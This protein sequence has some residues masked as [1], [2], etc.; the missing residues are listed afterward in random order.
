[1]I[2]RL[3]FAV[4]LFAGSL[5]FGWLLGRRRVLTEA[6]AGGLLRFD[7]KVLS[8]LVLTLLFWR[9]DLTNW[10]AFSLPLLGCVALFSTW[11]P[12]WM[13]ARL[14]GLS[15]PETGSFVTCAMFSNVGYLG[16]LIAFA[17]YGEPGYALASL[18]LVYFS[19]CFYVVAFTIARRFGAL[20]GPMRDEAG[21][22]KLR[23]YP[24]M[25][26]CAGLLL[27]AAHIPRPV[28]LEWLSHVLIPLESACY[29][30]AIGSQLRP[31]PM[32]GVARHCLAMSAIKFLYTPAVGWLIVW[33]TRLTG[34][35]RFVVLLQTCMP[36]AI[37][38]LMLPVLFG[39]DRRL[40]NALWLSTTILAIPVLA[41]YIPLIV[42]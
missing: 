19:P 18:H 13:Y 36:V 12:A 7:V 5:T 1:M 11:L 39:V 8:P 16:A 31:E 2:F 28:L 34:L 40:A 30:V 33:A 27:S 35:A 26:L 20:D 38:P 10:R 37:S 24:V 25:G 15:R 22:A 32:R 3:A 42:P 6:S 41:L 4:G 9:F 14:G 21:N 23:L 17:L 29:L